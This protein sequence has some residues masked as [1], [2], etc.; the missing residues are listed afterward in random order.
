ME[1]GQVFFAV[2]PGSGSKGVVGGLAGAAHAVGGSRH[3]VKGG[4]AP[5]N[6]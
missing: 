2:Q 1:G 6:V 3:P 5:V 4:G